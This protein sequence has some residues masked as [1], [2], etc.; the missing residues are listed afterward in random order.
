VG[1]RRVAGFPSKAC[2]CKFS[3]FLSIFAWILSS[4]Q[5]LKDK[6]ERCCYSVWSTREGWGCWRR[7]G[8][9]LV[10]FQMNLK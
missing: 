2:C 9:G 8:G 1:D 4:F 7:L 5:P 3:I 10:E 6:R